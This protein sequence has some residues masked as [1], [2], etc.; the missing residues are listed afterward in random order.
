MRWRLI[1][2]EYG[3]TFYHID[4]PKNIVADAL[5][6][7]DMGANGDNL[8]KMSPQ[9]IAEVYESEKLSDS[10]L[11]PLKFKN[12]AK[13]QQQGKLLLSIEKKE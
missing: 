4:G 8:Q 11:Y 12:I 6:R 7:L 1:L 5:S 10:N 13:E 2:E 9:L 3:P